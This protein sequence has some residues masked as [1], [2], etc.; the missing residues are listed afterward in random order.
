M[1]YHQLVRRRIERN[2]PIRKVAGGVERRLI[3][4][5]DTSRCD[6]CDLALAE[7]FLKLGKYRLWCDR[8]KYF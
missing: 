1:C 7:R 5:V 6:K 2:G 3:L 4:F 8:Y